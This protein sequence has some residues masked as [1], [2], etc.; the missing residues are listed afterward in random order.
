MPKAVEDDL[1]GQGQPVRRAAR[2]AHDVMLLR[3]VSVLVHAE[4][5]R[6]VLVLGRSRDDDLLRTGLAMS[7]GLLGVGEDA[8]RLDH[9]VGADIG[10]WQRRRVPLAERPNARAVHHDLVVAGADLTVEAPVGRVVL[11]QVR[12]RLV[13]REVVD[14]DDFQLVGMALDDGL[15]SLATDA[16]EAVDADA[17]GHRK[18]APCTIRF[19][20]I[21]MA[22]CRRPDRTSGRR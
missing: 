8:G 5:D 11:E 14:R 6:D 21:A 22:E 3:V 9:D 1:G 16:A 7:R 17:G 10:P 12:V 13:I 19:V 18:G 2:V 20:V 15:E 4:D